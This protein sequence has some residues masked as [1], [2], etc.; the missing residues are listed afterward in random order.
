MIDEAARIDPT[1]SVDPAV[2]IGPETTIGR[3]V[4]IE[5]EVRVGARSTIHDGARLYRGTTVEDGVFVGPNAIVTNDR[6]PRAIT[7]DGRRAE[8]ADWEPTSVTLGEG[9][10]IGAGAIVVAGNDVGRFA[11]VGAGAVVTRPV[12]AHA[13]VVGTPAHRIGWVCACGRRLVDSSGDPA[14]AEVERYRID[15]TLACPRCGRHYA[16]VPE[17]DDLKERRGPTGPRG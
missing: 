14:P 2:E 13:L 3:G 15:P 10:S 16:Y 12:P 11:L 6:Y 8:A 9:C 17:D 4:L 1:A 7:W 5:A